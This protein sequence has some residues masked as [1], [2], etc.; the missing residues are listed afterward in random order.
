MVK[1]KAEICPKSSESAVEIRRDQ[2]IKA[3]FSLKPESQA[4]FAERYRA[5]REAQGVKRGRPKKG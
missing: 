2:T 5:E 1:K 4:E 3:M